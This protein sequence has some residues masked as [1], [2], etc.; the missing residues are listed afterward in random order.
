M[1]HNSQHAA[2]SIS[3]LVLIRHEHT[4]L[5]GTFCGHLDPPLSTQGRAQLKQVAQSLSRHQFR[6]VFSSDLR[7]ARETAD[8]I[9]APHHLPT[10]LRT[11]LRELAFG[12]WEGLGWKQVVARD[13]AFAGR[14]LDEYPAVAAPGGEEFGNFLARV[15]RAMSEIADEVQ[16]GYAAIVTHAGVIRT[17]LASVTLECDTPV[18]L[19]PRL[20]GSWWEIWRQDGRWVLHG[21]SSAA[22]S[23]LQE[24][25][26]AQSTVGI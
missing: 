20:Y 26:F 8:A 4:D 23:H 21:C 15:Q 7:R 16:D 19:S 12:E 18:D 3:K 14:W 10:Q 24:Q 9:A 6:S 5:A 22:F 11:D 13:P 1:M 25:T 17:V 2:N